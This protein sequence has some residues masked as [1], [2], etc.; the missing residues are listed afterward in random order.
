MNR[1]TGKCLCGS[2][3]YVI[4]GIP[5]AMF[6]CHCSLCRKETGSIHGANIFFN[7]AL[8]EWKKDQGKI[9][10]FK[11]EGTRKQRAFCNIC[12]S[13]LPRREENAQV[14][15]P[16]GTLDDDSHLEP[17]AHIYYESRASY[18]DKL[19]NLKRFDELPQ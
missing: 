2:C 5:T 16:A 6:L 9:T 7:H 8:L 4:T 18:E 14:I 10:Y 19:I 13:P 1:Y 12:G 15:L 17:T 3:Q 11:L